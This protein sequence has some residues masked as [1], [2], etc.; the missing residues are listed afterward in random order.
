MHY[1]IVFLFGVSAGAYG[2]HYYQQKMKANVEQ[3]ESWAVR[4]FNGVHDKLDKIMS[5]LH[6][7]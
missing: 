4:Q 1:V 6:L 7:G 3:E 5:G 2:L